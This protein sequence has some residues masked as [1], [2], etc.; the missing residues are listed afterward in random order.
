MSNVNHLFRVPLKLLLVAF[1]FVITLIIAL[2]IKKL[3]E[4]TRIKKQNKLQPIR[5][6]ISEHPQPVQFNNNAQNPEVIGTTMANIILFISIV[7]VVHIIYNKFWFAPFDFL[8]LSKEFVAIQF[9]LVPYMNCINI[10]LGLCYFNDNFRKF[11]K[12]YLKDLL[13][14]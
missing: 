10:P 12:N 5:I 6:A 4:L 14:L 13:S 2:A 8:I 9:Q 3:I 7:M 1:V 11:L